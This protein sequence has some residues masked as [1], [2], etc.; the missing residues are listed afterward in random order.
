MEFLKFN[1]TKKRDDFF[2][3]KFSF[4]LKTSIEFNIKNF[5]TQYLQIKHQIMIILLLYTIV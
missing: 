5:I 4:D 2:L 3:Q 1:S